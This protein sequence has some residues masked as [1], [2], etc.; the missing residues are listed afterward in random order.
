MT[1]LRHGRII[2]LLL[3]AVTSLS[4]VSAQQRPNW[5]NMD[6]RSDSMFGI[7]T[8]RAYTELLKGRKHDPVIVAVIDSGV[9]TLHEDLKNVLWINPHPK[10][11]DDG[12]YGWDYI[13]SAKGNVHYDNLELTRQVRQQMLEFEGKDSATLQG[14]QLAAW[15]LYQKEKRALDQQLRT[16]KRNLQNIQGFER[17][18]DSVVLK[19]GKDTPVLKDFEDFKPQSPGEEHIVTVVRGIMAEG[20]S[21][22]EFRNNDFAPAL[23]HYINQ[24]EHYLNLM[25]DPRPL[26]VGDDYFNS[27]QS[28][29][30]NTDVSGPDASHG[31]HV[32]GIIGADRTNRIGVS[33]VAD[34]VRILTIRAVP[35]G[36]ER[37]KDIANAIRYAADHGA[38]VINM[39][40]GKGYSQDKEAVDKAVRYAIGKDVLFV[41][42]AG[43]DDA[44]LD[45]MP[46]FPNRRYMDGGEA[47]AWIVVG[48]SGQHD[49]STLKAPFSNYGR[50]SVD[51]FAPGEQIYSTI[52]GSRYAYYDG[53]SMAS[54]VVAGLA[55]L[56]REYYPRLKAIQVKDIIVQSVVKVDHPVVLRAGGASRFVSFNDLCRSGGVVNAYRAIQQAAVLAGN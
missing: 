52:P 37:D 49:D 40:F 29:Y 41:Q 23:E 19:I 17:L 48:A 16:A 21:Y 33:G 4:P 46:N 27:T 47:G 44:D 28:N 53:T 38:R 25:Y 7:S 43:N 54:P 26:W 8:E 9:D 1:I 22:T 18:L 6:L 15:Q 2:L 24:V 10:K 45:S 35:D 39:S 36:D 3:V 14:S 31:T 30:G 42:A 32:A 11:G 50:T 34:D 56:I 12:T 13:G 20:M 5:Q 55:A 51:V